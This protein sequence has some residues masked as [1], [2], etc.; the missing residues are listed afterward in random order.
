[1]LNYKCLSLLLQKIKEGKYEYPNQ[2]DKVPVQSCLFDHFVMSSF[3][4]CTYQYVNEYNDIDDHPAEYVK[5]VKSCNK[6]K[7][8]SKYR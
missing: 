6:E 8:V 2:I 7:E 5:A 4:I 3:F 1:M